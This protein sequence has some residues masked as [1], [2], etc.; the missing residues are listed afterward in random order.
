MKLVDQWAPCPCFWSDLDIPL[1]SCWVSLWKSFL[2]EWSASLELNHL[3]FCLWGI[4]LVANVLGAKRVKGTVGSCHPKCRL[5][6]S[7]FSHVSH[8]SSQL[9]PLPRWSLIH[10]FLPGLGGDGGLGARYR[11]ECGESL[12]F[13][14]KFQHTC[15]CA[16]HRGNQFQFL[17]F[18]GV[19]GLLL[20]A[21]LFCGLGFGFIFSAKL[22]TSYSSAFFSFPEYCWHFSFAVVFVPVFALS[23]WV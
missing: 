18:C 10:P 20:A 17:R 2:L 16:L 11:K 8:A 1:G 3:F 23:L 22:I 12:C 9:C 13:L 4:S 19:A 6:E 14:H 21:F 15:T 7:H 5:I